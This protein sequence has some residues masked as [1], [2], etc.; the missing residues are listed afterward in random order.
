MHSLFTAFMALTFLV[1]LAGCSGQSDRTDDGMDSIVGNAT[2]NQNPASEPEPGDRSD[3]SEVDPLANDDQTET[4][5]FDSAEYFFTEVD[6]QWF[7]TVTTPVSV[8]TDQLYLARMGDAWFERFGLVEWSRNETL[9]QLEIVTGVD[10][11]FSLREIFATNTLLEFQRHNEEG[12]V[13]ELYECVLTAR[14][15]AIL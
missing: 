3:Q 12:G 2:Q 6:R 14:N 7:C 8:F 10:S 9:D 13:S 15:V 1:L 5:R 4:D 11:S